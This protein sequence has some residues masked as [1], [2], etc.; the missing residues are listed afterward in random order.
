MIPRNLLPI[1]VGI[2]LLMAALGFSPLPLL[3]ALLVLTSEVARLWS[4]YSLARIEYV[5]E[6][7]QPRAIFGE[8]IDFAVRVVNRKI[9][10]LPWLEVDDQVPEP[11]PVVGFTLF[12][13]ATPRH[14]LL[15]N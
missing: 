13:S 14:S 6:F 5:R 3:I 11:L 2:F 9:L 8:E 15:S 12:P 4:K 10:P 7:G 1:S